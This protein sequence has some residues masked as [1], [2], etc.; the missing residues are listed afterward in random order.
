MKDTWLIYL[1]VGIVALHFVIGIG[2][3]IYK[4]NSAKP[5]DNPKVEERQEDAH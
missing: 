2:W 4:I 5:T 1:I 3:L